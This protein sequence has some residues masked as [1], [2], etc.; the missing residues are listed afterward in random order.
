MAFRLYQFVI[1][2][3]WQFRWLVITAILSASALSLPNGLSASAEEAEL[4]EHS[5]GDE[6]GSGPDL[7]ASA[8]QAIKD[9]NWKAA[10]YYLARF[11]GLAFSDNGRGNPSDALPLIEA[12][13]PEGAIAF[14]DGNY[15]EG[16]LRHYFQSS[17]RMWGKPQPN[18]E[19]EQLDIQ[20]LGE[21][22]TDGSKKAALIYARPEIE[23]WAIMGSESTGTTY[24]LVAV[25]SAVQI[26][27]LLRQDEYAYQGVCHK[28]SIP[29]RIQ[30]F[31]S[32]RFVDFNGDQKEE[33]VVRYNTTT[34]DGYI[35]TLSDYQSGSSG[36]LCTGQRVATFYGR[37]GYA[38]LRDN[39]IVTS[40]Q[41]ADGDSGWIGAEKQRLEVFDFSKVRATKIS[42]EIVDNF[43]RNEDW[44]T[45]ICPN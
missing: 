15:S 43:L 11:V 34:A 41:F 4:N 17:L 27:N 28:I 8:A 33:L 18:R 3:A 45:P 31:W 29:G 24:L 9:Q 32:P 44:H 25:D 30:E 7:L 20:I 37:N 22:S 5:K 13:H 39:L 38:A 42:E 35:Q 2:G 26:V 6:E 19:Q 12:A 1:L 21:K 10:D 23:R 16:F 14:I 40:N 36:D